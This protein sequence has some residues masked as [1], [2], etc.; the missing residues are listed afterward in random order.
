MTVPAVRYRREDALS[1]ASAPSWAGIER[2]SEAEI[3]QVQEARLRAQMAWLEARSPFYR[4]KLSEAGLSFA[5]WVAVSRNHSLSAL[6]HVEWGGP[7]VRGPL[8]ELLHVRPRYQCEH[9]SAR[10]H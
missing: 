8:A 6:H 10:Y 7:R 9:F 3:R 4:R 5:G 1:R 2:A